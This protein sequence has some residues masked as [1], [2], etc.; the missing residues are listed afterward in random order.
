MISKAIG[1]DIWLDGSDPQGN[2]FLKYVKELFEIEDVKALHRYVQHMN[3]SR[4]S[5]SVNVAWYSYLCCKR[6]GLDAR[7]AARGGILHDLYLYDWRI[8]KQPEGYHAKA[9]PIVALRTARK[10]VVLTD[11]EIDCIAKHMWPLTFSPPSYRESF[12]LSC[13]D[14]WVT[15]LEVA[16][17]FF[18]IIFGS[19]PFFRLFLIGDV[20]T[21]PSDLG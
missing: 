7:S 6:L 5:H 16:Y 19:S 2:E 15:I 11:I 18:W 21:S 17:Q 12:L 4:L 14:K 9:H 3:T 13:M 1:S 10:N 8:N 20:L